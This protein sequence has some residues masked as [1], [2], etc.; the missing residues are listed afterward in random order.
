MNIF[1]WFDVDSA[2]KISEELSGLILK[3]LIKIESK[4]DSI[5]M[6]KIQKT[7]NKADVL[8]KKYKNEN[9]LNFYKKSRLANHF[10]WSLKEGGCP[11]DYAN[12]L[13]DWL[14]MRL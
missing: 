3:D 2:K 9:E 14:V 6:T 1:K 7:L 13:T 11:E 4:K 12:K 5:F 8:I 10:L